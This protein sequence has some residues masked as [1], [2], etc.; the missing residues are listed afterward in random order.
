MTATSRAT[1]TVMAIMPF[2]FLAVMLLVSPHYILPFLESHIGR[3]LMVGSVVSI[4]IGAFLL[5]R[6]ASVRT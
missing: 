1:A 2:G 4:G 5:N 3:V 6:I